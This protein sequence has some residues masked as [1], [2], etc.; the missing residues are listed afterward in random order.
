MS[1]IDQQHS[2]IIIWDIW[3]VSQTYSPSEEQLVLTDFLSTIRGDWRITPILCFHPVRLNLMPYPRLETLSITAVTLGKHTSPCWLERQVSHLWYVLNRKSALSELKT[4]QTSRRCSTSSRITYSKHNS[5]KKTLTFWTE[6]I[7]HQRTCSTPRFSLTLYRPV[8]RWETEAMSIH[9][10]HLSIQL[11]SKHNIIWLHS[12]C[13]A[14]QLMVLTTPEI[15]KEVR[16]RKLLAP[17]SFRSW[18]AVMMQAVFFRLLHAVKVVTSSTH[19]TWSK[20]TRPHKR[21]R[22]STVRKSRSGKT[23]QQLR[24]LLKTRLRQQTCWQTRPILDLETW[25]LRW[26]LVTRVQGLSAETVS[27]TQVEKT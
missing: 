4:S 13:S 27:R 19:R 1:N 10:L 7:V 18:W 25:W 14:S 3:T 9:S 5:P 16:Q 11:L 23:L 26:R 17:W 20:S 21:P 22:I 8:P 15:C 2:M 6:S 24:W 12:P